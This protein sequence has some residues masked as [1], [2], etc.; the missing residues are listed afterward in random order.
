[1]IILVNGLNLLTSSRLTTWQ[2]KQ[3]KSIFVMN[4]GWMN[5]WMSGFPPCT[6]GWRCLLSGYSVWMLQIVCHLVAASFILYHTIVCCGSMVKAVSVSSL[7]KL[8]RWADSFLA[9]GRGV[10]GGGVL[11]KLLSIMGN[12]CLSSPAHHTYNTF[13]GRHNE[14]TWGTLQNATGGLFYQCWS[15]SDQQWLFLPVNL[16]WRNMAMY[17]I[18]CIFKNWIF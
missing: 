9:S 10:F 5:E 12:E 1:M 8:T 14:N 16:L 7:N 18:K 6:Q 3:S 17:D 13:T 4:N 15:Y 11:R 2:N